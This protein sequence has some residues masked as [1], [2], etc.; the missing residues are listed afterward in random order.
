MSD[1]YQKSDVRL[2]ERPTADQHE[3]LAAALTHL[4]RAS[5]AIVEPGD[6]GLL[7]DE[8][9]LG[10][11]SLL[12]IV[13][14]ALCFGASAPTAFALTNG[15]V[16]TFSN[17]TTEGWVSPATNPPIV[18]TTGGPAGAG[19]G[20][21]FVTATDGSLNSQL[22]ALN[23]TQW[24][25]NYVQAGVS[26][27]EMDCWNTQKN[28]LV[29]RVQISRF[30]P[31]GQPTDVAVSKP[32]VLPP[33]RGWVAVVVSIA[34]DDLRTLVGDPRLALSGATEIQIVEGAVHALQAEAQASPG[35]SLGGLGLDNFRA[36]GIPVPSQST[37]WARVKSIFR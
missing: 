22:A 20:Y 16:D 23:V 31:L 24:A 33:G 21:V 36:V 7:S 27:F 19:D 15:K 4:H 32:F 5:P 25:G 18:V 1:R 14:L 12:C 28:A 11:R 2:D 17:G 37:S 9:Q 3:R 26:A 34:P 8:T 30:S 10:L 35:A 13:A 29:L 6:P